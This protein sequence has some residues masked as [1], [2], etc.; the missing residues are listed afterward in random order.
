MACP[1]DF[2]NGSSTGSGMYWIV[3]YCIVYSH[4]MNTWIKSKLITRKR[5]PL[6]GWVVFFLRTLPNRYRIKAR[7]HNLIVYNT[8]GTGDTLNTI[9]KSQ[10]VKVIGLKLLRCSVLFPFFSNQGKTI[11]KTYTTMAREPSIYV[12]YIELNKIK[13]PPWLVATLKKNI[14]T[15]SKQLKDKLFVALYKVSNR[16]STTK[17]LVGTEGQN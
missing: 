15:L 12:H 7:C 3:L 14:L 16:L 1:S 11:A 4:L 6:L 8:G 10:L 5:L 13:E 17:F 2:D 9:F